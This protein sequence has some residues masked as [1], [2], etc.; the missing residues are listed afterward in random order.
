MIFKKSIVP[1]RIF[2]FKEEPSP[3]AFI[4]PA[5]NSEVSIKEIIE[6]NGKVGC[7]KCVR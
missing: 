6:K 1:T 3:V 7:I 2:E 4:C 5:C